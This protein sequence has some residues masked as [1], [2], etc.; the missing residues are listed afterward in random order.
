MQIGQN[1]QSLSDGDAEE[2]RSKRKELK[3]KRKE[4]KRERK[5][6]KKA[7]KRERKRQKKEIAALFDDVEVSRVGSVGGVNIATSTVVTPLGWTS[8][9]AL[10]RY[11]GWANWKATHDI[12]AESALI[13]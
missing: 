1:M 7:E 8:A 4:E 13:T 10:D 6:Q 2:G 5:R 12:S 3:R 9:D 11:T